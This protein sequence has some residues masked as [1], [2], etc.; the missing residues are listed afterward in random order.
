MVGAAA[1][2]VAGL[3]EP[4][5]G[6]QKAA[7]LLIAM[8]YYLMFENLVYAT[9]FEPEETWPV[10]GWTVPGSLAMFVVGWVAAMVAYRTGRR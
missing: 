6:S 1:D 9:R 5:N 3:E 8:A 2:V 4:V 7:A 10:L